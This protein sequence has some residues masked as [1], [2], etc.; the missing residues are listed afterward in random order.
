MGAVPDNLLTDPWVPV[1]RAGGVERLSL[2]AVLAAL[3]AGDVVALAA[4]ARHVEPYVHAFFCQLAVL[5]MRRAGLPAKQAPTASDEWAALLRAL[6]PAYPDDAPWRLVVPDPEVPAFLQPA[7]PAA[8][9]KKMQR[10][11]HPGELTILVTARNHTIKSARGDASAPWAWGQALIAVQTGASFSGRGNPGIARMNGGFGSRPFVSVV[12]GLRWDQA[13]KR[14]VATMLR[15]WD[16]TLRAQPALNPD[17]HAL[18]WCLP[19]WGGTD[20]EQLPLSALSPH[21]IEAAR[22]IRLARGAGGTLSAAYAGTDKGR[23]S[24]GPKGGEHKGNVGDPWAPLARRTG[25][26][27]TLSEEGWTYRRVVD[28][29]LR[30]EGYEPS[31]LQQPEPADLEAP[32]PHWHLRVLVGGQGKTGGWHERRVPLPPAAV[33][34]VMLEDDGRHR[35]A[36]LAERH[37]DNAA[38]ARKALLRG[39]LSF[40]ERAAW[41]PGETRIDWDDREARAWSERFLDVLERRIDAEF[42][43]Y[44]WQA[45][46][47]E[48]AGSDTD[49]AAAQAAG[50]RWRRRLATLA[51]EVFEEAVA[52]FPK[53]S[54]GK[55]MAH[56]VAEARLAGALNAGLDLSVRGA[57]ADAEEEQLADG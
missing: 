44:L 7:L 57:A 23:V 12:P 25:G 3:A 14:D 11:D 27:L 34:T 50:L 15:R 5:A 19:P 38:T 47:A 28:L 55:V 32:D 30:T 8:H 22:R 9:A 2:S 40:L 6:T 1:R 24:P 49:G 33:L 18:L 45:A 20:K 37:I 35:V 13:W 10:L 51:R 4:T 26:V 42:F 53:S 36:E 39:L 16:D 48:T 21:F 54:M 41:K 43:S 46:D 29:L 31:L 52:A 17:G 56:A